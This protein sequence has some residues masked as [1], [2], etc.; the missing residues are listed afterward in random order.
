[1][2]YKLKGKANLAEVTYGVDWCRWSWS[3]WLLAKVPL[4]GTRAATPR[5]KLGDV[6]MLGTYSGWEKFWR[7]RNWGSFKQQETFSARLRERN[8][9]WD[10]Q[11][12]KLEGWG[13]NGPHCSGWQTSLDK[14]L[15][16]AQSTPGWTLP[17]SLTL[18]KNIG[19]ETK[20][21]KSLHNYLIQRAG[22]G[23]WGVL[24]IR[25]EHATE[26]PPTCTL[27]AFHAETSSH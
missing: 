25:P 20:K 24:L 7:T 8:S 19:S 21:Q 12:R 4:K 5:T 18:G 26:L 13:R 22:D 10:F 9:P 3:C 2:S 27:P 16:W 1:M 15:S 23:S 14:V 6:A 11:R 17:L